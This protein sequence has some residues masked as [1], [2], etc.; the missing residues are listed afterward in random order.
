MGPL[1][2]LLFIND[3]PYSLTKVKVNVYADDTSLTYSDVKLDN[4]TQEINANLEELKEWLQGNK[5]SLNIDKTT[6]M[7][8][9]T[10]RKLT[11]EN[12]ENLLPNFTLDGET[13]QHK[14]ATKYLGVQ[15]DNQLKW[16]DHISKV[17]SKVVRA[18]GYI[19]YARKFL[20]RETLRMLY[21]GL[22]EP[23]FRYCCA[24]WGSC[25]TVLRQEIEKLQNRAVRI[26]TFS[27]YNAQ[28]SP[29]LKHLK[30]PSIQDM[31]Q[32]ETVGIYKAINN[33][34]PEYLSVLFNRVSVMT[35]RT[36][37]NANIN[38]TPP[39]P[40]IVL[41]TE[42]PCFGITCRQKENLQNLMIHSKTDLKKQQHLSVDV[43]LA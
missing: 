36:I 22:V 16:K 6:S 39:L 15:I 4:V 19:K 28:A 42:G 33:Q 26:I 7:I 29:L 24:V 5:L 11:D 10:K 35:G 27:P 30:L 31:I 9:G 12:G 18:I 41:H 1:L 23:H 40:T 25:G 2:F 38:L 21:L 37:R 34:A 20:P 14:N 13:I 8:I 3:M 17:S 32:Q 43:N